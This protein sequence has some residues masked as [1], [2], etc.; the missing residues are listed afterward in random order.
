MLTSALDPAKRG[1]RVFPVTQ[2]KTPFPN[3]HGH[4]EATDD[5]RK[6]KE[7]W[8]RFPDANVAIATGR[9]SG[10]FV[11]DVDVKEHKVGDESLAE[12]EKQFGALPDSVECLTWSGGRQIYFKYPKGTAI[13]NSQSKIGKDLD[14][15]GEGGY[16]VAP[17]SIVNGRS[18]E[19]EVA[20]HPD[21]VPVA[22]APGW[23]IDKA[24]EVKKEKYKLPEGDI[25]QGAQN[26]EMFR[27]A[28]SLKA[29]G[30]TPDMVRSALKEALGK[31]PQDSRRPFAEKDIE[32]WIKSA[33]GY[34]A[35]SKK[36]KLTQGEML[37]RDCEGNIKNFLRDQQGNFFVVLPFDNHN[38]VRQTNGTR[39]RNW[40]ARRF[41]ERYGSP[42]NNEA[43]KQAQIQVEAR[44][45]NLPQVE[46]FNR[47]GWHGDAIYYDLTT[48]DWR[49]VKITRQG[50]Q[51]VPLPPIFRRHN[52]QN[53]Q[54][55]PIKG[56]GPE[57]IL[58]FC[59]IN[60]EDHSL[61]MVAIATF[62]IPEIPHVIPSQNGE[63][64][65]GKSNNSR[66]IKGLVDPSKAVLISSPKDLEQAQ[67]IADKHW[68]STFDNIS[69]ISAWFSDFLC[70]AV[71][72]EGD[73]KRSLYTNDEEFIR[74]YRRC[75]VLNG[76][77]SLAWRPDLLDRFLIFEIPILHETR[78][79]EQIER[80]WK[81]TLPGILGG[82]FTAISRAMNN[83]DK[84]KGHEKFR[85]ADFARWGACLADE[86]GFSREEF[87]KKYQESIEQKWEDT[88]EGSSL[89]KRLTDLV[90]SNG[91][92]W[93]GS[94]AELLAKIKPETHDKSI[95]DNARWLSTELMKIAPVMRNV[96]IDIIGKK[97]RE[98]GTG[99]R[100]FILKKIKEK[101]P[102][103]DDIFECEQG[104]E[105]G[106][107]KSQNC[108]QDNE[109]FD[110]R[111][112]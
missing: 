11:L 4:K 30:F 7:L 39:F 56:C 59:N 103:F 71:T 99:R 106:V 110:E 95:P 17:G 64:G 27:F 65:T 52:H 26:D 49:G 66:M 47:V 10:I 69:R 67:M 92:E 25:P 89:A 23:L 41:R 16:V 79:E 18:Y 88:A 101:T 90:M 43:L 55:M 81:K 5:E 83:V 54:V 1:W 48:P 84:V 45:E 78:P 107:S 70:R 61:F 97:K 44:C 109:D 38:E 63:Q 33:F 9:K 46:L 28:C 76:I 29:Q 108:E 112:F 87:F 75:F 105:Q 8:A 86:L 80:E 42:P 37:T 13:Y 32:R 58:R 53:E 73:M 2:N 22:D 50:W 85:M 3:T 40:M 100:L 34:K 104:C 111:P 60:K 77:G 36:E 12:L 15:R 35:K 19:W 74:S 82:F 102:Y 62:F 20:H 94:A 24:M 91:G 72:G 14:I 57:E 6:I 31:C 68:L 21:D 93:E 96:G 51:I 98:P